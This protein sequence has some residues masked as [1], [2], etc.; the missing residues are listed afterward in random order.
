MGHGDPDAGNPSFVMLYIG[1][2]PTLI[3]ILD[4]GWG[5]PPNGA[6]W[7]HACDPL[8]GEYVTAAEWATITAAALQGWAALRAAILATN[9][10]PWLTRALA[11]ALA[12]GGLVA[13]QQKLVARYSAM[14]GHPL[15]QI[16]FAA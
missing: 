15:S 9:A 1:G 11:E 4:L 2:V 7:H 8:A 5:K 12:C 14:H 10:G 16:A 6:S 13:V 3:Y